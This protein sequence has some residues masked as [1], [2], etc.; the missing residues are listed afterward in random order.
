MNGNWCEL[1]IPPK[2]VFLYWGAI[3]QMETGYC[4]LYQSSCLSTFTVPLRLAPQYRVKLAGTSGIAGLNKELEDIKADL[5]S[6][7]IKQKISQSKIDQLKKTKTLAQINVLL[8]QKEKQLQNTLNDIE[9]LKKTDTIDQ[10]IANIDKEIGLRNKEIEKLRKKKRNYALIIKTQLHT[11]TL[12]RNF[13]RISMDTYQAAN[14]TKLIS[15]THTLERSRIRN[16]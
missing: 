4:D 11:A 3:M 2:K 15:E 13:S 5:S 9:E 7:E 6:L 16:I 10:K 12:L 8:Q 1:F 14:R